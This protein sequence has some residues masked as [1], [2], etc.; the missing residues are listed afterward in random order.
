MLLMTKQDIKMIRAFLSAGHILL[1]HFLSCYNDK[2]HIVE[3]TYHR[4]SHLLKIYSV[5][6]QKEFHPIETI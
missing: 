6:I 3:G 4:L 5:T 1:K 2:K